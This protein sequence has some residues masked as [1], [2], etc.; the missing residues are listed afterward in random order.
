MNF[1]SGAA[2]P[3]AGFSAQV[4]DSDS[5][6]GMG[7]DDFKGAPK[8]PAR[9]MSST[10]S[11]AAIEKLMD[12]DVE[13][14][15]RQREQDARGRWCCRPRAGAPSAEPPSDSQAKI[16]P[17]FV[18]SICFDDAS[19]LAP[20]AL[21]C[22]NATRTGCLFAY[23]TFKI[24]E[25]AEHVAWRREIL[26]R[27][28]VACM[29]QFKPACT[30]TVLL[31]PSPVPSLI[32]FDDG[33]HDLQGLEPATLL[34]PPTYY[35][36]RRFSAEAQALPLTSTRV[37]G[38]N[39]T[40][41]TTTRTCRSH[42]SSPVRRRRRRRIRLSAQEDAEEEHE[43]PE[44]KWTFPPSPMPAPGPYT[45]WHPPPRTSQLRAH[46]AAASPRRRFLPLH[47][48][49]LPQPQMLACASPDVFSSLPPRA[50][51]RQGS[52]S[53][54]RSVEREFTREPWAA[55]SDLVTACEREQQGVRVAH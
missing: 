7:M 5:K 46:R 8:I 22:D 27:H 2:P 31:S 37:T 9:C 25:E 20:L 26:V 17:T 34:S 12:K 10:R 30:N 16:A 47:A 38:R 49:C 33:E 29:S 15:R 11:Q 23:I 6:D 13:H 39:A 14:I 42:R 36:P 3:C 19:D 44:V 32:A 52:V 40:S 48:R 55:G 43:E 54:T 51:M 1:A 53:R 24:C 21:D 50:S 35:P 41:R 18:Y 28:Y 45:G 4:Q